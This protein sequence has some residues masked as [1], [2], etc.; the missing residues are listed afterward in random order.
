M[1]DP[2][3]PYPYANPTPTNP[4]EPPLEAIAKPPSRNGKVARLPKK[5]RDEL[6]QMIAD[7][8]TYAEVIEKLGDEGKALTEVN[9]T[10]WRGGG[11]QEWVQEQQR[12]D[13]MR[14]RQ[15]FAID[16][17]RANQGI[18]THQAASQIAALN[19]CDI[20]D[21]FKAAVIRKT[22]DENPATYAKLL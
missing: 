17:V 1:N 8:F 21:D 3:N 16:L 4:P 5:L 15:E 12:L 7:G 11:Y 2:Q 22:R 10:N 9:V 14:V 6:N 13:T 19:L 18:T 20:I